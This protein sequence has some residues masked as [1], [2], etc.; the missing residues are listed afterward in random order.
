MKSIENKKL[1]F[2]FQNKNYYFFYNNK[3]FLPNLTTKLLLNSSLKYIKRNKKILD[4]G[5]GIG[6]ISIILS[7]L[8]PRIKFYASD[9]QKQNIKFCIK[10]NKK[11]KKNIKI[12]NG[13]VF[14]P[15]KGFKFDMIINDL[16]GVSEKISKLSPW[17]KHVPCNSGLDG[18]SLI[19]DL[20][21]NSKNHLHSKGILVF[22]IISLSNEKKILNNVKKKFNKTVLINKSSWFLPEEMLKYK[23]L[24]KKLKKN[25]IIYYEDKFGKI[26]CNTKIY[27][28]SNL[29]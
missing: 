15:W 1:K 18:S 23:K 12:K 21:K 20:L 17:F 25:K 14:D 22:P 24:L 10:N 2:N 9:L 28:A 26:V 5:C 16:S 3:C 29:K 11:Y 27:L 8:K 7:L 19:N 4:L 13:N 6:V